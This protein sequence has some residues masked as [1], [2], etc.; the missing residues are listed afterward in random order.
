MGKV[1]AS[2]FLLQA[3][4]KKVIIILASTE[5]NKYLGSSFLVN[6]GICHS[7]YLTMDC[8]S[9]L[10]DKYLRRAYC[11]LAPGTIWPRL[12]SALPFVWGEGLEQEMRLHRKTG[13]WGP[14]FCRGIP[15]GGFGT[16]IRSLG[17][18]WEG[19]SRGYL[20]IYT[21]GWFELLYSRNQHNIVKQWSS[22]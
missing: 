18:E 14:L 2:F 19:G 10:L 6:F 17:W 4:G 16:C 22:N 21:Y 8:I 9:F 13:A 12:N 7:C 3:L 15:G 11:V 1:R 5:K 20:Y